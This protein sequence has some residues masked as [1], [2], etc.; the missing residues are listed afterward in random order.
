MCYIFQIILN[1]EKEQLQNFYEINMEK[2]QKD[3]M[4]L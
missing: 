3:Q 1:E 4:M 2:S